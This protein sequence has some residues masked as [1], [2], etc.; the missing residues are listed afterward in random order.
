VVCTLCRGVFTP[1]LREPALT[2]R[3]K[4]CTGSILYGGRI[5]AD[6]DTIEINLVGSHLYRIMDS[7]HES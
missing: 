1:S 4:I 3:W 5:K 7:S 6:F 2:R